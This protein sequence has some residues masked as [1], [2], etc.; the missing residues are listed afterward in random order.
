MLAHRN[1]NSRTCDAITIIVSAEVSA[2]IKQT[3]DQQATAV[4]SHWLQ[5]MRRYACSHVGTKCREFA[6]AQVRFRVVQRTTAGSH[7][8]TA[9]FSA[10]KH[11]QLCAAQTTNLEKQAS[12]ISCAFIEASI[13]SLCSSDALLAVRRSLAPVER[14]P[15]HET[16]QA[17]VLTPRGSGE[18]RSIFVAP[19]LISRACAGIT[20]ALSIHSS[21]GRSTHDSS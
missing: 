16:R 21:E 5:H 8:V 2:T 9:A 3:R 15:H 20:S 14:P 4:G 12:V 1:Q 13:F 10:W 18:L 19:I 7:V 6:A 17:A 11:P